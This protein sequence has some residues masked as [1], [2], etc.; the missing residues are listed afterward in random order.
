MLKALIRWSLQN[1]LVVLV[2]AFISLIVGLYL[3]FQL[4]ID[5]FPDL[6][7]PTVTVLAEAHNMAPEEVETLVTFP[8]ETS[9]NGATSVR[10]VRSVS[11]IGISIVWAE[12]DWGTDIY[13]A[14]QIVSE[15]LQLVADTLPPGVSAP[16]M[17]PISSVM[18]EIM[19]IAV[20]GPSDRLMEMRTIA[21]WNIRRRLLAVTGVSQVVPIGGEVRQYQVLLDL[22]LLHHYGVRLDQVVETVTAASENSSGGFYVESGR[23]YLVRG[24]GRI[25]NIEQ[26]KKTP[27][28]GVSA[29]SIRLEQLGDVRIGPKVRRGM[30]SV[31]TQEAVI[32]TVQKQPDADTLELTAQIDGV[33]D[34]IE[35]TLPQGLQIERLIFRQS[36]FIGA[37]VN[38]V[39][40]ALRDGAFLVVVILFLFLLNFRT[41]LISVLAIPLSL[42]FTIYVFWL[43][44]IGINTMT[45]GGM[46]IAIGALVDDAIIDVE[47]V[48]RKLRENW[49]RSADQ[50]MP[51]RQVIFEASC[52]V[53]YPIM[54]ATIIVIV[55]FVPLFA[56]SGLEGR[57]LRPLG[58]SYIISIFG[59]LLVALT[60]TPALC[61]YLLSRDS[62]LRREEESWVVRNLKSA[63]S[64]LLRFSIQRPIPVLVL[65]VGLVLAAL[66]LVPLMGR[67]FLPEFNEGTLTVTMVTL[68]GTSLEE[69][70]RLG[71]LAEE[72]LLSNPEVLS[73]AR[74]TGRAELDE[75]AQ[76]VNAAEMD[77]RFQLQDRPREEF[78]ESL[79]N[80]LTIIPGSVFNI[81]QPISHR[82]DHMLS[83]IQAA[84]AVKLFGPD[85]LRLRTL[86][87]SVRQVME[88]IPGVVDLQVD[89]QAHVPQT[90]IRLD[91]EAI[92]RYGL[93]LKGVS[94]VVD[95]GLNGEVVGQILEEQ[96]SYDLLVRFNEEARSGVEEMRRIKIDTPYGSV[97]PLMELADV[98]IDSG[99]NRI[100]RENVQ[101]MIVIQCNV[102]GGDLRGTVNDV[103]DAIQS[104]LQLPEGYYIVYGGQFESE[105]QASRVIGLLSI[106]GVLAIFFILY[107][108]FNSFRLAGLM[109]ANLP[110]ALIGG[111]LAV[112]AGGGVLSI[113]SMVGFVTLVGIATRNG[114]LLVSRYED[115]LK[116]EKSLFESIY[117]GSMER[118]SPI[119]MTALT[120]GL[121]L[122]PLALA[123]DRP[124]NEIQAPLAIVVL[125]GLLSS[126][127]LNMVVL[128]ALCIRFYP[129]PQRNGDQGIFPAE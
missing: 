63:Y 61:S 73:T 11:G 60:I 81:G 51:A 13:R 116:E 2:S 76:E 41:T 68:P 101:R 97:V 39:L 59:S 104:Q 89:Q 98:Q 36:D 91:R 43:F 34:E 82:I 1:R 79:R 7:A 8:I 67:T 88:P 66:I 55:V 87:E 35:A 70:N 20:T 3:A 108:A 85:L 16:I 33:L 120:T 90:Q 29:P 37:A 23:E 107:L 30:A 75:H 99:P 4:P 103:R 77:V 46:A 84:V 69:S 40:T 95:I 74:R 129:R 22:D 19:L 42:I 62:L 100:S 18:G 117:Q 112:F 44:D 96:E 106:L 49:Q 56:L 109:M 124:G 52:E 48:F 110:L 72:I 128:P 127:F 125:G 5:V 65:A 15:K 94:E 83:G 58:M 57:M 102:A 28:A 47:I 54:F 122:I 119:L 53:R 113:A 78:L 64:P 26:L 45:L 71:T 80:Q 25:Q 105:A 93:S 126:A 38:N 9:L 86:A 31:N 32:L 123:G 92:G 12:F 118:L 17:A 21:D 6:T 115:L 10:R 27:V 14:R 50:R 111:I 24:L 114:I 121:A